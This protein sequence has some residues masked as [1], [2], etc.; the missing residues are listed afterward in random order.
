MLGCVIKIVGIEGSRL[1]AFCKFL[2]EDALSMHI[3]SAVSIAGNE[4]KQKL[5]PFS[6]MKLLKGPT[7]DQRM[8][9]YTA[10]VQIFFDLDLIDVRRTS[11]PDGPILANKVR[12]K[13]PIHLLRDFYVI[14]GG[15]P[16]QATETLEFEKS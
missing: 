6:W 14:I 15:N 2:E 7:Y 11:D 13:I 5:D 16:D 3:S 4:E 9:T 10:E 8:K 1:E 12:A